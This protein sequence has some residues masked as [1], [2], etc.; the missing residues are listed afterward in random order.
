MEEDLKKLGLTDNEIKVYLSLLKIGETPIGGIIN[1]IKFH[2]QLVYNALDALEKKELISK[3]KINN[4]Y[5]FKVNDPEIFIENIKK[6]ELIAERLSKNLKNEM[7]AS[8]HV[9]QI[10]IYEGQAQI[11]RFF[12][13]MFKSLPRNTTFHIL[14]GSAY[15]F[16]EVL[17]EKFLKEKYDKIR[18]EKNISS[19]LVASES[20]RQEQEDFHNKRLNTEI[21]QMR[22]LPFKSINPVTSV[23]WPK[24]IAYQ[25]F[26]GD[27]FLFEIKNQ[28][29]RNSYYEHFKILWNM[30]KE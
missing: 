6:Q 14:S 17:G 29:L 13:N 30:G 4:I 16:G 18:S 15:R 22:F 27:P 20:I 11:R 25:F 26:F 7:Q 5:H 3:N 1:D 10:E 8:K 24:S 12:I 28:D 23:I 9:Q 2:R 19:Q 21:R